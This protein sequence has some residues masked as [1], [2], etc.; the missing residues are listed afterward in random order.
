MPSEEQQHAFLDLAKRRQWQRVEA[1]VKRSPNIINVTPLN[2]W[3]A[4]HH[5]T[6]QANEDV[7]VSLVMA[8]ARLNATNK[9]GKTPLDMAPTQEIRSLLQVLKKF[10]P[11]GWRGA[12]PISTEEEREKQK[13]RENEASKML[14][15][16]SH[17]AT[18]LVR[19]LFQKGAD[20]DMAPVAEADKFLK[21]FG[22]MYSSGEY[23]ETRAVP[24]LIHAAHQSIEAG[25]DLQ[26]L[27]T[28]LDC[29]ANPNLI[30]RNGAEISPLAWAVAAGN[31]DI[32]L[33]LL[34]NG[35]DPNL[36]FCIS[37]DG[38]MG[39]DTQKQSSPAR[40]AVV[41]GDVEMMRLL[42]AHKAELW[43]TCAS[44][45]HFWGFDSS[46]SSVVEDT[47]LRFAAQTEMES[48]QARLVD[49]LLATDEE[50][51]HKRGSDCR[52]NVPASEQ[53]CKESEDSEGPNGRTGSWN[54]YMWYEQMN[55]QSDSPL[56]QVLIRRGAKYACVCDGQGQ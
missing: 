10:V 25:S 31:S 8:K 39:A 19:E 36:P 18:E 51:H 42:L 21:V 20:L 47:L 50:R 34:Q 38:G 3:S 29:G 4:L 2:R 13:E 48:G 11:G 46:R 52:R 44:H 56:G 54:E 28:L 33:K 53:R 45:E 17:G 30:S 12:G 43:C 9:E 1:I 41:R 32:V 27:Q 15:A 14:V 49:L 40:I 22:D 23:E 26:M 7:V 6:A 5:A 37:S 35:A 16:V 55:I 24:L